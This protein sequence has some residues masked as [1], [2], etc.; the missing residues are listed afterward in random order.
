MLGNILTK[1]L[2]Q[3]DDFLVFST[4]RGTPTDPSEKQFTASYDSLIPDLENLL[5]EKFDYVINAIGVIRPAWT[6]EDIY[7]CFFMNSYFPKVLEMVCTQYK[8]RLIHV[9]TDCVFDGKK[10]DY[11]DYDIPNETGVY[12]MSKFLWETIDAPH[13]TLRTSIIWHELWTKKNLLDWF[14]SNPD[15][16]T[17]KW[18]TNVFWNGVTTLVLAQIIERIIEKSLFTEWWLYQ[19]WGESM[20]KYDLLCLVKKIYGRDIFIIK[21]PDVHSNK[22]IV[23]SDSMKSIMGN[24]IPKLDDQIMAL[25]KFYN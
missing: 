15:W 11:T 5:S 6:K 23:M 7:D 2:I 22:S 4:I 25:N 1:Y 10:W 21:D 24:L 12:G 8:S 16:S 19:I 18:Y 13:I 3:N 9:S 14:L 20:S 17:V